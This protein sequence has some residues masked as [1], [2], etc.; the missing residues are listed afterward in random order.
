MKVHVDG[1]VH[2]NEN[3]NMETTKKRLKNEVRE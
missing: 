1:L 3:E 2:R